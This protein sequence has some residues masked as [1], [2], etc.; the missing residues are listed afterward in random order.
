MKTKTPATGRAHMRLLTPRSLR[1][2]PLLPAIATLLLLGLVLWANQRI[3]ARD[4]AQ[5]AHYRVL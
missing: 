2:L 3:V 4:L 5:R 1:L